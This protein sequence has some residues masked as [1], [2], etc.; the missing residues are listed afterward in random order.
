MALK[1][2]F[3][4]QQCEPEDMQEETSSMAT[5]QAFALNSKLLVASEENWQAEKSGVYTYRT[6]SERESDPVRKQKL[7]Q[8]ADAEEGH[9]SL[10]ETRLRELG[11]SVEII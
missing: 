1:V 3:T 9:A 2:L 4:G 5:Q 10:W 6:L 8:L 7:H 11:A